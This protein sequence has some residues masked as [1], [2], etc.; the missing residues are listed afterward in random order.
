MKIVHLDAFRKYGGGQK[1][2][3]NIASYIAS[4]GH[5]MALV[6][7]PGVKVRESFPGRLYTAPFLGD[8]DILTLAKILRVVLKEKA[9]IVH[10]HSHHDHW[11]GSLV[12]ALLGK[13]IKLIHTRH[14]DF[15]VKNTPISRF[16]YV[17]SPD[18]T[19]TSCRSIKETMIRSLGRSKGFRE[20][21]FEPILTFNYPEKWGTPGR[22]RKEFGIFPGEKCVS[23]ITRIVDNK[24]HRHLLKAIPEIIDSLGPVRFFIV[25]EGPYLPVLKEMA[26]ELDIEQY[27]IFTGFRKDIWD[28]Y[29]DMDLSVFPT[30]NE[31]I[32]PGVMESLFYSV[33]VIASDVGGI[34][35][36][37]THGWNG[38]LFP[39]GDSHQLAQFVIRLFTH[40]EEYDKLKR[41]C[42]VWTEERKNEDPPGKK[43][44]EA[45]RKVTGKA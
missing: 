27:V 28:F 29:A 24:G 13:R 18:Y 40:R 34:P 11:M 44:L 12:K 4:R 2:Y 33:P 30:E 39:P 21:K 6:S 35:E 10:T 9:D 7:P 17:R 42:A 31:G 1:R 23:T 45:Y 38:L 26:R 14:V 5:K 3:V 19:L 37:I 25:G 20:E 32:A 16:M 8:G 22:I 43:M 15:E 41:N 36:V